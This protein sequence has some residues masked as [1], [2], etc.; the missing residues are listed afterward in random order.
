MCLWLN[1]DQYL[2]K[3]FPQMWIFALLW[4]RLAE[5]FHLIFWLNF[6]V[7]LSWRFDRF[8]CSSFYNYLWKQPILRFSTQI[9]QT[10]GLAISK[11]SCTREVKDFKWNLLPWWQE[12]RVT[13]E[14]KPLCREVPD[15]EGIIKISKQEVAH[16][17]RRMQSRM[18]N[19]EFWR[20]SYLWRHCMGCQQQI[21]WS[22]YL[23]NPLKSSSST[24]SIPP[25][26]LNPSPL[27]NLQGV[28][29]NEER[30]VDY[31]AIN[32]SQCGTW[33]VAS[34]KKSQIPKQPI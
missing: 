1:G 2:I 15:L 20:T 3:S 25:S 24:C 22:Y 29:R 11:N 13:Q 8:Y 7:A 27:A 4:W 12:P 18:L 28:K 32:R 30:K 31:C 6:Y 9:P 26:W 10:Y 14:K 17:L 5:A 21:C 16:E 34:K 33:C 23:G 19:L